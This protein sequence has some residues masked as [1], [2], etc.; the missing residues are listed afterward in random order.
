M[1]LD[2]ILAQRNLGWWC[3]FFGWQGGTIHQ[4]REALWRFLQ[5]RNVEYDNAMETILRERP[6]R[7]F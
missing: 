1:T 7:L 3:V 6:A 5:D 4:A 2:D